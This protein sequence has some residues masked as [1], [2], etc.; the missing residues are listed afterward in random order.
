M[1]VKVKLNKS[2]VRNQLLKGGG[3]PALCLSIAEQMA[4]KCGPGYTAR[5]IYYPERNGA[6]VGP[7]TVAARADNYANNTLEKARGA[8][9]YD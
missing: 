8:K 4:D 5:P 2:A 7:D 1:K 6:I 9:Y 3:A